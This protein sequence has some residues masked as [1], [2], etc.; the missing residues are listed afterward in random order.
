LTLPTFGIAQQNSERW[1]EWHN[2]RCHMVRQ[3]HHKKPVT[4]KYNQNQ[5]K[6]FKVHFAISF[7]T[8]FSFSRLKC[9]L[10]FV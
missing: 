3:T 6:S 1:S 10:C 7:R 2:R 9:L 5:Q 4:K 8:C